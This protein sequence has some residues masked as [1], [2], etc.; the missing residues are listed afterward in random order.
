MSY[1][2]GSNILGYF[3]Q[4]DH[5]LEAEKYLDYLSE[6]SG[7]SKRKI[8]NF[9]LDHCGGINFQ[10]FQVVLFQEGNFNPG[11]LFLHH[12]GT[13]FLYD[14]TEKIIK[15]EESGDGEN[16]YLTLLYKQRGSYLS[17]QNHLSY[18]SIAKETIYS[19]YD[20][21]IAS[22]SGISDDFKNQ[23]EEVNYRYFSTGI[24]LKSYPH[25]YFMLYPDYFYDQWQSD[26]YVSTAFMEYL[27]EKELFNDFY[28]TSDELEVINDW[29]ANYHERYF[30]TNEIRNLSPF[31]PEL[32]L[33]ILRAISN[34]PES[35]S[36]DKTFLTLL[37]TNNAFV[38]GQIDEAKKYY[39]ELDLS[40]IGSLA[41]RWQ[42][43]NFTFIY[44]QLTSITRALALNKQHSEAMEIIES[45][46]NYVFKTFIYSELAR[47]L[48]S[49]EN[50]AMAFTYLDSAFVN[51]AKLSTEEAQGGLLSPH[52]SLINTLAGI[53][54]QALD[55]KAKHVCRN[56]F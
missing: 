32:L 13:D 56:A 10:Y 5:L 53:G 47:Y 3:A 37:L 42:Y 43:L 46:P 49:H 11:L 54:S 51:E 36:F 44:N 1:N 24:R 18:D 8:M 40:K 15:E 52:M 41:N 19:W 16:F 21:A 39:S 2:H 17:W 33:E 26:K 31:A 23:Q 55:N 48:Y 45:L 12:R 28:N 4:F 22:Y 29:L 30:F 7:L 38:A 9:T 34:H 50:E 25:K 35:K 6:Q 20:K 14:L 27:L